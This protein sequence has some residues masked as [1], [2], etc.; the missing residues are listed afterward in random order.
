MFGIFEDEGNIYILMEYCLAGE[1]FTRIVSKGK[2]TEADAVKL[3][4]GLLSALEY[5]H[6]KAFV[7]HRDIKPENLLMVSN[8]N[9]YEFKLADFGLAAKF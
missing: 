7:A 1:L 5:L 8:K 9:N 2:F 3:I 6:E 4:N